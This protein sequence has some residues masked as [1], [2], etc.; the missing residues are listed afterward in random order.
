[1]I[2]FASFGGESGTWVMDF[3]I[4]CMFCV[5][6]RYIVGSTPHS[7]GI[8][9]YLFP[10]GLPRLVTYMVKL[11]HLNNGSIDLRFPASFEEAVL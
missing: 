3:N 5:S 6:R 4:W 8:D 1:M 2:R 9:T 7:F 11:P 10:I